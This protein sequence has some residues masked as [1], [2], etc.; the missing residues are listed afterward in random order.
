MSNDISKGWIRQ[1]FEHELRL[2]PAACEVDAAGNYKLESTRSLY[3]AFIAGM[4]RRSVKGRFVVAEVDQF[5]LPN[6]PHVP[7]VHEYLD[8]AKAS[9][10]E[11]A[12]AKGTVH[13]VFQ[14][15]SVFHPDRELP[16]N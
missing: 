6:F 15:V 5:G 3:A 10:R 11:I 1:S 9:Q 13:M 14:Q 4:R 8:I 2:P 7:L 12:L 16:K